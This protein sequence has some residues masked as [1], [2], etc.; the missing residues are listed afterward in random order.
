MVVNNFLFVNVVS[1]RKTSK[2]KLNIVLQRFDVF[3]LI[4]QTNKSLKNN[5][6]TNVKKHV[7]LIFMYCFF[8]IK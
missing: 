6:Q 3:V 7:L 4:Y 5:L 1:V 8:I 2:S